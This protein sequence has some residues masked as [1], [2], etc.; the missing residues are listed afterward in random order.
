MLTTAGITFSSIGAREN[1][2]SGGRICAGAGGVNAAPAESAIAKP[3][4]RRAEEI[5]VEPRSL[6]TRHP[7]SRAPQGRGY[8]GPRRASRA[9]LTRS[10]FGALLACR[11]HRTD[12]DDGWR[13]L[14]P[15]L[16]QPVEQ[17][18]VPFAG[19]LPAGLTLGGGGAAARRRDHR[20]PGDAPRRQ[21]VEELPGVE[22]LGDGHALQPQ[23]LEEGLGVE[24]LLV[25]DTLQPQLL[26]ELLAVEALAHAHAVEAQ[27][28]EERPGVELLA[29]D[30][31]RRS[32]HD[33]QRGT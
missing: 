29:P 5:M 22:A 1:C 19:G 14:L 12:R 6:S 8:P 4:K 26:E 2:M 33:S 9:C 32:Q 30:G 24:R 3:A 28:L 16:A 21:V 11:S 20:R 23:L 27:L 15:P 10:R 17:A 18:P 13:A 25:A 7:G 31:L